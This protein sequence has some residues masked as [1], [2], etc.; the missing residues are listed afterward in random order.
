MRLEL[1]KCE[2]CDK[3]F[4]VN[5]D[6][7]ISNNQRFCSKSCASKVKNI[8]KKHTDEWKK[9]MSLRNNGENNPFFGKKH[10][11]NSIKKMSI[12]SQWVEDKYKFCNMSE[13][14]KEIFDG[15]MISDGSLNKSRIS[16]RLTLGFKYLETIE[17]II[18]DLPSISF[19][20]PWKYES[21]IDIRTNKKYISYYTKSNS[22]RNLLFEYE[23]WYNVEKIIPKDIKITPLMCYWWYV[24]D[25]FILN[26]NV[27]LCTDSFNEDNLLFIKIKLINNGF[28]ASI[29]K[30][31]R[32][33]LD[34]KSSIDFLKWISNNI[35]IQK[36]YL[37]KWNIKNNQL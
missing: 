28:N 22:Y 10:N 14:E 16:A 34:K 33:S 12:S 24:C 30:N 37:Y 26:N 1:R 17:K 13:K 32:I 7:K 11:K 15:I 20:K 6:N 8:G 19:I 4:E 5:V 21:N 27:Y 2:L 25:G 9:E 29:R 36:E 18:N 23:R 35:I 3:K 31:K